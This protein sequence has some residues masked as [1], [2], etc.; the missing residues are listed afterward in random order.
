M[1]MAIE[2]RAARLTG[3]QA[4]EANPSKQDRQA[5]YEGWEKERGSQGGCKLRQR[6][7]EREASEES[8][9]IR[10]QIAVLHGARKGQ[11]QGLGRGTE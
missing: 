8:F 1:D 7:R 4:S 9:C 5:R 10:R 2:G 11:G 3:R 6:Y